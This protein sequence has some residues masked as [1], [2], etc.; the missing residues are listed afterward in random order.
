MSSP[1]DVVSRQLGMPPGGGGSINVDYYVPDFRIEI[2]GKQLSPETH[3][4][5]LEL[6]VT[7]ATDEIGSFDITLNNWND[8]KLTFKYSDS[9]ALMIGNM[10]HVQLGYVNRLRSVIHGPI[11]GISPR[12]A[13]SGA[14]SVLYGDR[15]SVV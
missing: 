1:A 11:T 3:G 6:K 13:D 15:K 2:D 4:D 7:L 12:F 9:K 14:L 10:V 5:V 8:E